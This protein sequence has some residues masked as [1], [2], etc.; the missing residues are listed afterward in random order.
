MVKNELF[1]IYNYPGV[2][3][4]VLVYGHLPPLLFAEI[5]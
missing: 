2:L 1:P 5:R 4:D 3:D